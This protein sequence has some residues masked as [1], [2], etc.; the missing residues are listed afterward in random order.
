MFRNT[1]RSAQEV[2]MYEIPDAPSRAYLRSNFA[3]IPRIVHRVHRFDKARGF[4]YGF[5]TG[6]V[7][8]WFA[9]VIL[10]WG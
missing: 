8:S 6:S 4:L 1:T 3:H 2:T 9:V 10:I 7:I 5:I